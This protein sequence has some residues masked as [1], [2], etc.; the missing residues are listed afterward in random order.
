MAVGVMWIF[1]FGV[2]DAEEAFG[3]EA[4]DVA[5]LLVGITVRIKFGLNVG[6][7]GPFPEFGF[8]L[9]VGSGFFHGEAL[10]FDGEAAGAEVAA[11]QHDE[12]IAELAE[13]AEFGFGV[14]GR[15]RQIARERGVTDLKHA[16]EF[17]AHF[18]ERGFVEVV[19]E[20]IFG[21]L[22]GLLGEEPA[23]V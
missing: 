6:A 9:F 11:T 12:V 5:T 7:F 13:A 3:D 10:L 2:A 16:Q 8:F 22:E 19:R 23:L 21:K 15:R 20:G 4:V 1:G 14:I 18:V 17:V